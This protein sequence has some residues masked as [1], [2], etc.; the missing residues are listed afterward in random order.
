MQG[1]RRVLFIFLLIIALILFGTFGYMIVEGWS[2]LDALYMTIISISTVGYG[3]VRP[4]SS[5]GR[6]FTM[7]LI[8]MGVGLFFYAVTALAETMLEG[9]LKGLWEKRKMEKTISRLS[10][11]FIVC[12][13]GRIGRSISDMISKEGHTVVVIEND[14]EALRN[15]QKAG[16]LY[17]E[18]DATQD[19]Y[20]IKAGIEK[21]RGIICVLKSD[22][23]NVYITLTSRLLNPGL[24]IV[25]R[26]SDS[27]A[28]KRMA[29]AGANKVISPYEIGA[30]R[31]ALSVLKPTV[32]EFL[33]LA[34][35]SSDLGISIEQ[36]VVNAGSAVDGVTIRD[37][38]LRQK[39]GV[40]VLAV[41]K[42]ADS[43][44]LGPDPD[45][46]LKAGDIVIALGSEKGLNELRT[47]VS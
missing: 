2:A 10:Q 12:G 24:L 29:Q 38:G 5:A 17:I 20:L 32:I 35:H 30:R 25:A 8:T 36:I 33:D 22:A 44:I 47:L 28:E 34:V 42:L 4:L 1:E 21:A 11:H 14:P 15:T 13:Y 16:F 37:I 46:I 43:M 19:E 6:I 18:G 31:M 26:A 9:H 3:E 39:T 7:T 23:D 40:T 45:Y 27:R 41:Q